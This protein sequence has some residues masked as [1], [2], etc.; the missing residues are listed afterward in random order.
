MVKDKGTLR[1]I[2]STSSI[3]MELHCIWSELRLVIRS[4][5]LSKIIFTPKDQPSIYAV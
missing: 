5:T 3:I 2:D 1:K 4:D